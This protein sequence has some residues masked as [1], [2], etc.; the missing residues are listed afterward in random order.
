MATNMWFMHNGALAHFNFIK[1]VFGLLTRLMDRSKWT[2][3][4]PSGI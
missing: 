4:W 1:A 2:D 3:L